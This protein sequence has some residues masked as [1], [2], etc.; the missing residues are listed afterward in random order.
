MSL[1]RR[2]VSAA[3]EVL[4]SALRD[5]RRNIIGLQ[6]IQKDVRLSVS[7]SSRCLSLC[8]PA[9]SGLAAVVR[10]M[11]AERLQADF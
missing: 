5:S 9:G 4:H 2:R 10:V 11:G 6:R 1:T 7:L 8:R 3:E